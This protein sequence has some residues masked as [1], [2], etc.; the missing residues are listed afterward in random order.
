[1]DSQMDCIGDILVQCRYFVNVVG[2][3]KKNYE[4]VIAKNKQIKE[5]CKVIKKREN[6]FVPVLETCIF[7]YE[8]DKFRY[9]TVRI[10]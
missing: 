9:H 8:N 5:M 7:A 10:T 1:M 4:K 2:F 3:C 6:Y